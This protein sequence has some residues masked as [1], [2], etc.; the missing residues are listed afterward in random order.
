M[1]V[2]G[3]WR[4]AAACRDADP[5]LFFPV[6][7]AGPAL[8]QVKEAKRIC[9]S[10]PAQAPCLAWALDHGV[11]S[12]VWGGATEGERRA[13][14]RRPAERK[15][16]PADD[17]YAVND[18]A[19]ENMAYVRRLLRHRQPGFAAALESAVMLAERELPGPVGDLRR[20]EQMTRT[21]SATGY[22][23]QTGTKPNSRS[24]ELIWIQATAA[25]I[26]IACEKMT[27]PALGL[28]PNSV[29]CAASLPTQAR[30]GT[31]GRRAANGMITGSRRRL[32]E[33]LLAGDADAAER[34]METHLR[35]LHFMWRLTRAPSA[36]P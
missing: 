4:E 29:E 5:D 1:T 15:R 33:H 24:A 3:S 28:L 26:R 31:K 2:H 12:G 6:G 32:L 19:R 13:L 11:G 8:R 25:G 10:C 30:L 27:A 17:G 14:R 35:A 36:A 22:P 9:Q 23:E 18:R 16:P 34:E 7:T 21:I 20:E